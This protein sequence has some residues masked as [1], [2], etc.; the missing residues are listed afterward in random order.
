MEGVSGE[1]TAEATDFDDWVRAR[2]PHLTRFARTLT[3]DEHAAHD[4]VQD[5]LERALLHWNRIETDPDAYVRRTMVNRSISVWRKLS[6][7]RPTDPM[8]DRAVDDAIRDVVLL[9][10]LKTL[11]PRQRAVIALRY[12]EDLTEAQTAEILGCS[13]GTVKSQA[14]AAIKN[15]RGRIGDPAVD[16]P[17]VLDLVHAGAEA[18][19]R[20]RVATAVAATA[21]AIVM[22]VS[23]VVWATRPGP[24]DTPAPPAATSSPPATHAAAHLDRTSGPGLSIRLSDAPASV[25]ATSKV[26]DLMLVHQ[27][28]VQALL[29]ALWNGG[30][31]AVTVQGIQVTPTTTITCSGDVLQVRGTR[32][33][34]PVRIEAIGDQ[35]ALTNALD[36]DRE[37]QLYRQQ[38]ADPAIA[39]GWAMQRRARVVASAYD[40]PG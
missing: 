1:R 33:T 30:A 14:S 39:L 31:V 12:L 7:E 17:V 32:T 3:A 4:L 38:A 21:T 15:L 6:R 16:T 8:P 25:R 10:A 26:A 11:A 5:T 18:R 34:L 27:S 19:R 24:A 40:G 23:G 29:E 35:Q 28:D 36:A 22:V 13:I 9:E 20:R 37:V 2:L